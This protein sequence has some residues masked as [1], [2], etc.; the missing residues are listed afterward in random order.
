[1][2]ALIA[3]VWIKDARSSWIILEVKDNWIF[4][5]IDEGVKLKRMMCAFHQ[6]C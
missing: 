4:R 3:V 6:R 2:V 5:L 1:M